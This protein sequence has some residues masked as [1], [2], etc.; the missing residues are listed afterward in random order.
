M[1]WRRR[2]IAAIRSSRSPVSAS[3]RSASSVGLRLGAQV[4]R[5]QPLA[6]VAIALQPRLD[7]GE[8]GQRRVRLEAGLGERL[9]SG[10]QFERLGDALGD[11]GDALARRRPRAPRRGRA[12][13]APRPAHRA[14]RARPCR[15]RPAPPRRR[16]AHRPPRRAPSRRRRASES[17]ALRFS[18]IRAGSSASVSFSVSVS[19]RRSDSVAI[20]FWALA[21]RSFQFC[22]STAIAASRPRAHLRLARQAL[23]RRAR[24]RQDGAVLVD[25]VALR[26]ERFGERL[27]VGGCRRGRRAPAPRRASVSAR[28][29]VSRASASSRPLRLAA[30]RLSSRSASASARRAL[31]SAARAPRSASRACRSASVACAQLGLGRSSA[32]ASGFDRRAAPAPISASSSARRLRLASR[33]AAARGASAA[34]T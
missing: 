4:D 1:P 31:S 30:M 6:L 9:P 29:A 23:D 14:P 25:P 20:W 24:F 12:A 3:R 33:W 34:A 17:S 19:P 5:A 27:R 21:A 13:R 32:C 2:W 18:S 10:A 26:G 16:R 7:V 11:F 22:R 8:L 15:P 28:L